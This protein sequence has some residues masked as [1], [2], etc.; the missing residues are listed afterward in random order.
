MVDDRMSPRLVEMVSEAEAAVIG[1]FLLRYARNTA[2]QYDVDLRCLAGWCR[3]AGVDLLAMTPSDADAY[4]AYLTRS[5]QLAPATVN[6][7]LSSASSFFKYCRRQELGPGVPFED[8]RRPRTST[9]P[10]GTVL[11]REELR[12]LL[13]V[14]QRAEPRLNA[15][16]QLLALTGIRVSELVT[17]DV[18][19]L[20]QQDGHNTLEVV[21]K[22]G[23]RDRVPLPEPAM[24]AII[25]YLAG[26]TTGPLFITRTGRRWSRTSV[27]RQLQAL[28][29][30]AFPVRRGT[31]QCHDLRRT[32]ATLAL[33]AKVPLET[34][35]LGLGHADPA[36]TLRYRH[37]AE[38]ISNQAAAY[39]VAEFLAEGEGTPL[40]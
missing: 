10:A 3:S 5:L 4:A 12:H 9:L 29:A 25:A 19:C 30:V 33:E 38:R 39:R 34:V 1:R 17:A 16:V 31:L 22:G 40:G 37:N 28:T 35:Q 24:A 21:R 23:R 26:R 36:T 20:R 6:R 15:A 7:R 18:D 2:T 8:V 32:F 27:W 14:A 13:R 11:S